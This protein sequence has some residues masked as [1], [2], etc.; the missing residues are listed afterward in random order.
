M[1]VIKVKDLV[2]HI[3]PIFKYPSD[4]HFGSCPA[5]KDLEKIIR[6][7]HSTFYF[8]GPLDIGEKSKG[9]GIIRLL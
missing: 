8:S 9:Q 5:I 6:T 7:G 4:L 2:H 3:D 1:I